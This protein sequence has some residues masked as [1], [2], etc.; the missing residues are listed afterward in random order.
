MSYVE[1]R[2]EA[3]CLPGPTIKSA[4]LSTPQ[5]CLQKFKMKEDHVS[6]VFKDI[7]INKAS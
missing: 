4:S 2:S 7:K 6:C 3:K 5:I 1:W